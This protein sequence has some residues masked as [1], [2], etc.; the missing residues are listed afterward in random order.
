MRLLAAD[1]G[2]SI[3]PES[4]ATPEPLKRMRVNGFDMTRTV[5]LYGVAGRQRTAV[6]TAILKLLRSADWKQRLD[7]SHV[8]VNETA[9]A[10]A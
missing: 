8:T 3:V 4:T 1:F 7:Q 5:R 6:A 9:A 10:R 2:I